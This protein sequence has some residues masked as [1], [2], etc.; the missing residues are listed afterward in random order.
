[1]PRPVL[2]ASTS[3]QC[4]HL[5]KATPVTPVP[6]VLIGGKPAVVLTTQY[7]V[8]GCQ[9]PT[10]TTGSP[11]CVTAQFTTGS[12]RVKAL[13]SPLLVASSTGTSMPNGTPMVVVPDQ[14]KVIA[15]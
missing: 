5:G 3:I 9:F 6:R 13:G 1:M 4:A 12:A 11:P 8:A 10:M 15:Q 14:T 2:T 7:T